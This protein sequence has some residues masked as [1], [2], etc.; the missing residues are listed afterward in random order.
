METLTINAIESE[1]Y[2]TVDRWLT[3]HYVSE[4]LKGCEILK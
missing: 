1:P 2:I 4:I 3:K